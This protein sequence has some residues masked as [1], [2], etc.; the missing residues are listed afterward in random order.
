MRPVV[1]WSFGDYTKP[2]SIQC[3]RHSVSCFKGLYGE[4]FQYV[5]CFNGKDNPPD[6][7]IPVIHQA[8][9]QH[10]LPYPPWANAWKLCPP[11]MD[12]KVHEIFIDIDLIMHTKWPFLDQFLNSQNKVFCTSARNRCYGNYDEMIPQ[13]KV[14]CTGLFGLPPNFDLEQKIRENITGPFE[15]NW[16]DEQG[17]LARIFTL[18][19]DFTVVPIDDVTSCRSGMKLGK[20]GTHFVGVNHRHQDRW[21]QYKKN[22]L[23]GL[24]L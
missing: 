16:F 10:T 15:G 6:L 8:D 3:L 9:F 4:K 19:D 1:R 20:Y 22:E 11:R 21:R 14:L 13:E 18:H 5:L 2:E 24:L 23:G 7:K 17:L 12:I